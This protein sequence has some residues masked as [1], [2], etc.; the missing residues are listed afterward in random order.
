MDEETFRRVKRFDR[1]AVE[2]MLLEY[3]PFVSRV[4]LALVGREDV[5][6]GV[7]RYVM[8]RSLKMLPKWEHGGDPGR[9]YGHHAVISARR[10]AGHGVDAKR[11]TL[12]GPKPQAK[13]MAFVRA[14]RDLP[15]QQREALVLH[16]CE[17]LDL[18]QTAV[19][20]DCS[21]QA[22]GNHL[23]AGK[24]Q[25]QLIAGRDFEGLMA[26]MKR[27]YAGLAPAEELRVPM[28]R[29]Y[30]RRYLWP[31]RIRRV[32]MIL[33]ILVIAAGL[34]FGAVKMGWMP[35]RYRIFR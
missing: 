23:E 30:M 28:T 14:L 33:L 29:K 32:V 13:Y 25:L 26:A 6:G 11:D 7:V 8:R 24:R 2:G 18:R 9:W 22:A 10:A 19:A 1:G 15:F 16:D 31:K 27:T 34:Y 20:M 35:E 5:A 3:Y 4:I 17:G 21:T 12:G